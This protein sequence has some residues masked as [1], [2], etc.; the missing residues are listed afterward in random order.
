MDAGQGT[1]NKKNPFKPLREKQNGN[2]PDVAVDG[3]V[4]ELSRGRK[5]L[6]ILVL[7]RNISFWNRENFKTSVLK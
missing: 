3:N 7:Q 2:C 6:R 5:I 4:F 1:Q